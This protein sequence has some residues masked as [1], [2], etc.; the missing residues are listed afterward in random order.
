MYSR[1]LLD[2]IFKVFNLNM[3][4]TFHYLSKIIIGFCIWIVC[5][6]EEEF[7]K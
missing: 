2:G 5:N 3:L 4:Q 1:V 6:L 7:F